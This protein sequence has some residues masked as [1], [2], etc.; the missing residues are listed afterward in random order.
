MNDNIFIPSNPI[1]LP[2][3]RGRIGDWFYYVTVMSFEEVAKRVKLPKEI[4]SYYNE[5]IKLED[6]IQRE[7][8][9]N[10]TKLI[11]DYLN[12]QPQ[13]FFNSLI[14][15]IYGGSP[16]W[17]ELDIKVASNNDTDISENTLN[18]L[19]STF[20]VLALNGEERIFA[21]D[22][23]HRAIGIRAAMAE[24]TNLK[25]EEVPLI[26][27]SHGKDDLGKIRTRRLFS[28]LNRYAKPVNQ[29]EKIALSEDDNSAIL[30]RMLVERYDKFNEKILWNKT[31]VINPT[32]TK[33]FSN[34]WT[35]YESIQTLLTNK[36]VFGIKVKGYNAYRFGN[37]RIDETS[38]Q[39]EYENLVQLFDKI[40]NKIPSI[41]NFFDTGYID[42]NNRKSSLL[43][44]PIGQNILFA[45][46]KVADANDLLNEAYDFFEKDNFNLSNPI[47]E[48]VFWDKETGTLKT[49]KN[50]QK[51]AVQLILEKIGYNL[52]KTTK[53]KEIFDSYSINL[54]DL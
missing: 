43:F 26:F 15:G 51:Y 39:K 37:Q 16:A 40:I 18:Y 17:Q 53:D 34:I 1:Y 31:R 52:N 9:T 28:T 7:L 29:T 20:G 22:G 32:N 48:R 21:I 3:L 19:E 47:W 42:R 4:D 45:V 14:L 8:D 24:N 36:D 50:K 10:R 2:A 27:I 49:E 11:I 6:W 13:R 54:E 25:N 35:L 38:L 5:S 12:N 46:L 41:K 44:R 30:A 23:Q 33:D